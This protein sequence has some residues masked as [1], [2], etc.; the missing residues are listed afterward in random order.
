[1][2]R[3]LSLRFLGHV[4]YRD[5]VMMFFP[6]SVISFSAN[7]N[8]ISNALMCGSTIDSSGICFVDVTYLSLL[9]YLV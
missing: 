9:W 7:R 1:M 3:Q 4:V 6:F 2:C 5:H 8:R